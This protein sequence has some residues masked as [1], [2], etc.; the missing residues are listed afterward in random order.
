MDGTSFSRMKYIREDGFWADTVQEYASIFLHITATT[1]SNVSQHP[2][3]C[4]YPL[5]VIEEMYFSLPHSAHLIGS[6]FTYLIFF[7][8]DTPIGTIL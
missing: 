6:L 2:M 4:L 1:I 8:T 3:L 5:I 7:C